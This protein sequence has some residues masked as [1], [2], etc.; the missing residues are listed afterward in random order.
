MTQA[1]AHLLDSNVVVALLTTDHV[2]HVAA[3]VW[4]RDAAGVATSPTTQ[5]AFLRYALRQGVPA[6]T[7]SLALDSLLQ[8]SRHEFWPDVLA[9]SDVNLGAVF[10]H[11]QV[12]DAYLAQLARFHGGRLAT[13]DRG[14]AAVAPDVTTLLPA[15]RLT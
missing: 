3:S 12:T 9:Y 5:A 6:A 1:S 15:G 11:R 10:G 2:H 7:A 8:H 13:F 4:F 14:L